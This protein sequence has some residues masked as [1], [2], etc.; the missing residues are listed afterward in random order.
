MTHTRARVSI[1]SISRTPASSVDAGNVVLYIG[2][3]GSALLSSASPAAHYALRVSTGCSTYA[4]CE[5]CTSDPDCGWCFTDPFNRSTTRGLCVAGTPAAPFTNA[6]CGTWSYS[7]CDV[8]PQQATALNL[9][10]AVGVALGLAV[11]GGVAAAGY[12]L[13]RKVETDQ[14]DALQRLQN[15][16]SEEPDAP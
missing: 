3:F 11:L 12:A 9:G 2:V 6:Y 4:D 1:L 13:H 5:H 10:V 15:L 14:R 7:T 8:T 16:D